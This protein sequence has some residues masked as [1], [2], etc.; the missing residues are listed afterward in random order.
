MQ[1]RRRSAR[2]L[3]GRC[4]VRFE[5]PRCICA[6]LII[7]CRGNGQHDRRGNG[8]RRSGAGDGRRFGRTSGSCRRRLP[9]RLMLILILLG[10]TVVR[11]VHQICIV[12]CLGKLRVDGNSNDAKCKVMR[13]IGDCIECSSDR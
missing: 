6:A 11:L 10:A 2:R 13:V 8:R 7:M 1:L 9:C 12:W 3:S 4:S 5:P